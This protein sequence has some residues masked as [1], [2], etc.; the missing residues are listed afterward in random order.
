MADFARKRLRVIATALRA[1]RCPASSQPVLP[2]PEWRSQK[3]VCL[4]GRGTLPRSDETVELYRFVNGA[5][6]KCSRSRAASYIAPDAHV[7]SL[8]AQS[9]MPPWWRVPFPGRPALPS[10]RRYADRSGVAGSRGRA[11][12]TH[13]EVS[14]SRPHPFRSGAP[15]AT[16]VRRRARCPPLWRQ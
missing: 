7:H 4:A 13:V 5:D 6:R 8:R 3:R 10:I 14:R 11:H 12:S 16:A 9:A 15:Q 2:H 1:G